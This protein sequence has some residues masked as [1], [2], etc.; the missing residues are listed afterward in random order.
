MLERTIKESWTSEDVDQL[1]RQF[2]RFS[3]SAKPFYEQCKIWVTQ[4]EEERRVARE[5]GQEDS[6]KTKPFGIS[7]FG[8]R[9]QFDK[10]LDTLNHEE[11]YSRITCNICSDVPT[12]P[13]IT[14]VCCLYQGWQF[15]CMG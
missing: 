4:S 15:E 12:N 3:I 2:S 8:S 10:A 1:N 7:E 13:V 6:A 14:S 9:F 5:N 11:L